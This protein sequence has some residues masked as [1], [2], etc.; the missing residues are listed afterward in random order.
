MRRH[1]YST[2]AL[3]GLMLAGAAGA[4]TSMPA[5]AP[6]P[7]EAPKVTAL[8][9]VVKEL[10]DDSYQGAA[11]DRPAMTAPPPGW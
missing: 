2:F 1:L 10:A 9:A 11:P 7:G 8:W 3:A 5:A 4:Q 6:A